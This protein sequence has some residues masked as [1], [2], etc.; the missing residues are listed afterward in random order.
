MSEK[1]EEKEKFQ[2]KAIWWTVGIVLGLSI[3]AVVISVSKRQQKTIVDNTVS[4]LEALQDR[5]IFD[6]IKIKVNP[7][8]FSQE[9]IHQEIAEND[10]ISYLKRNVKKG[11]TVIYVSF[12]IGVQQ[13][14]IAKLI[15]QSGRIYVFNPI[16]RY[17]AAICLSADANGFDNRILSESLAISD[18]PYDGHLVYK[19]GMPLSEGSLKDINY[20]GQSGENILPVR[21]STLD[22]AC[23]N[24][25]NV[26]LLR[27]STAQEAI[28]VIRGAKKLIERSPKIK[29][30]IDHDKQAGNSEALWTLQDE[31]FTIYTI[32]EQGETSMANLNDIQSKHLLLIP[33]HTPKKD[34]T[35][36]TE[37]NKTSNGNEIFS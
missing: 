17:N 37:D 2:S 15:E 28:N 36:E 16:E 18:K 24:L 32:D 33:K 22:L 34:N 23:A 20:A 35:P 14:L 7:D 10:I 19:V 3:A 5:V 6:D 31:G 11:D 9:Q 8:L 29:I 27:I 25:Q 21:V 12:D 26:D 1:S 4:D 30:V 13:L